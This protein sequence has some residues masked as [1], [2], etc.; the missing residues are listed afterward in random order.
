MKD[1]ISEFCKQYFKNQISEVKARIE[2]S[3]REYIEFDEKTKKNIEFLKKIYCV[4][5]DL[6]KNFKV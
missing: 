3:E 6:E 4:L 5:I 1:N 2:L